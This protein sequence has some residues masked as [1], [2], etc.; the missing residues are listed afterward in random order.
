MNSIIYFLLESSIY[1]YYYVSK[2]SSFTYLKIL[3]Y[4]I[5]YILLKIFNIIYDNKY[6]NIIKYGP[7]YLLIE[8]LFGRLFTFNEISSIFLLSF[9]ELILPIFK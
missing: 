9:S 5:I 3:F 2:S 1:I 4:I 6:I 8:S 7:S